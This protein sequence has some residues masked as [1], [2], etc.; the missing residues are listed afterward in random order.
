VLDDLDHEARLAQEERDN[1]SLRAAVDEFRALN[2]ELAFKHS[3][4]RASLR[5]ATGKMQDDLAYRLTGSGR[6]LR[7]IVL[8]REEAQAIVKLCT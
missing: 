3:E 4:L 7:Y 6:P 1:D 2:V 5:K 8:T